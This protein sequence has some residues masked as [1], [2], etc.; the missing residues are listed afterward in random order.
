MCSCLSVVI[1]QTKCV[2]GSFCCDLSD[3]V[4]ECLFCCDLSDEVCASVFSVVIFKMKCVRVSFCLILCFELSFF[5]EEYL[6]SSH[7]FLV[8]QA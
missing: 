6:H 8:S 5:V 7:D 4:Y 1:F 2:R 3:E